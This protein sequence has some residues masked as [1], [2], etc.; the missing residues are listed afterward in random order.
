MLRCTFGLMGIVALASACS[1]WET[2]TFVDEGTVCFGV[3]PSRLTVRA[4][5][6]L[7]SSCSRN[8][9]GECTA[10]LDG[11]ALT[12]TSEISWE[13]NR[14][15]LASCTED[16]GSAEVQ[17]DYPTLADGT[18]TVHFGGEQ[19]PL[20]MPEDAGACFFQQ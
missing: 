14:G 16:C 12:V 17:C 5:D 15:P 2:V 19:L 9:R 20:E 3:E 11:T 13:D 1:P 10:R 18:Y 4:P 6:C 8:V 7:S